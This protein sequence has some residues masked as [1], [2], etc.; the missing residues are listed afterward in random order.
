MAGNVWEFVGDWYDVY[1]GGD[2]N[3][4]SGKTYRVRRGG[5]WDSGVYGRGNDY[6]NTLHRDPVR[7]EEF[8]NDMG[9]RCARSIP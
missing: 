2:P 8:T 1:P 4:D 6:I 9:F 3:L 7:A 5:S